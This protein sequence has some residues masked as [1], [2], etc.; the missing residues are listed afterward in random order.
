MYP[1]LN[2]I[3]ITTVSVVVA[4]IGAAGIILLSKPIDKVIMFGL[5]QGGFIGLVVAA[6][7]LDVAMVAAILDPVSTVIMLTAIIK[8]DEIRKR[9]QKSLEEEA[10]A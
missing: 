4:F 8:L 7:Y 3:N 1:T 6:K 9:K 2:F 5:L 10:I